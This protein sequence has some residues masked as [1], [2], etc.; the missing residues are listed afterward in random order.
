MPAL[1]APGGVMLRRAV[2]VARPP[3]HALAGSLAGLV[4]R[5][6]S[7]C[8]A[9]DTDA[10]KAPTPASTPA[11]AARPSPV[12]YIEDNDF[13]ISKV[14]FG[15]I[16]TPV[17]SFLLIYGF[18]A[19]FT[20]LPGG[21]VSSLMLIYGFPMTLLGFA[22][23]YAQLEPAPCKTTKAAFERRATECT[24]IQKQIREDTTRYRYGDEQH[25][26]EALE[27][28]FSFS[29][30]PGSV[31]KKDAPVLTGLR[32]EIVDDHYCLVLEFNS[33]L[34]PDVWEGKAPKFQS[35]FGPGIYVK[36]DFVERGC[37][38]HL[39]TDGSGEG[40][41]GIEKKDAMIPL[42]P[43]LKPRQQK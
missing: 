14:S 26:E 24:D 20:L 35:F 37:D 18:G 38:V 39:I 42:L 9:A 19:F 30:R 17:G 6:L 15:S 27:K 43:G 12:D 32:E 28:I 16:L 8:R 11:A 34:A 29:G 36:L 7:A 33:K 41:T 31:R 4:P 21:D 13:S 25:L 1:A 10:T 23:W 40:M 2:G 5:R 3:A 22:L